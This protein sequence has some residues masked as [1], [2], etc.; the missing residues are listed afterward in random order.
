MHVMDVKMGASDN[1]RVAVRLV[2][3]RVSEEIAN[4]RRMKLEKEAKKKGRTPSSQSLEFAAWSIMI[5]NVPEKW[6][7]SEM[8]WYVYS[9]RWQIELIFKEINLNQFYQCTVQ[10]PITSIG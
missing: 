8:L 1:T 5:T 7:P 9:L 2:C 4:Q 3:F 6:I 10:I